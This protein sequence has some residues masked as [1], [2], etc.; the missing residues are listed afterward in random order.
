MSFHLVQLYRRDGTL[1]RL[2][3]FLTGVILLVF[4]HSLDWLTATAVFDRPWSPFRYF[5]LPAPVL[6]LASLPEDD[7]LFYGTLLALALPFIVVGVLLTMQRLRAV[8]LPVA[9][10]V[11]FFVPVANLFFFLVLSILPTRPE[12]IPVISTETG[13]APSTTDWK[14]TPQFRQVAAQYRDSEHWQRIRSTHRRVTHDSSLASAGLSLAIT[15][16]VAIAFVYLSANVLQNYGVGLFV[17]MPFC[18]GLGSVVLFGLAR[19]QSFGTC[20]AVTFLATTLVGLGVL[21]IALEG[22][23]CLLMAAPLGYAL[24]FLG[25]ALGYAIQSRPWAMDASPWMLLLLLGSLPSLM[26]AEAVTPSETRLLEVCSAVEINAPVPAV[27]EHVISFPE[28]PEPNDWLFRAGVAYPLRA[29]IKGQGVGAVRYCVFSTGAFVEPIEVWDAPHVLGF[30]VEDQPEPM[31]EWSPYAIH[32][33]HLDGYLVSRRGCFH[34]VEL[35]D[36][37]TRLEGTTWYTNRMWPEFY[38]QLWSD[39]IIHRIHLR[40]LNHIKQLTE[41]DPL[42]SAA[43]E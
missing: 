29:E 27:W 12:P 33:P 31:R 22:A 25:G 41:G 30:R 14:I 36:G 1:D 4:K 37:R 16:P 24:A 20:M 19:P 8:G 6:E 43:R 3:Y 2:P 39:A 9:L 34:L 32:P 42:A 10:I 35:P 11:L 5:V 38:W 28:L 40:V 7:R 18:V 15:V 13:N 17:G 26:A 21:F 23:I